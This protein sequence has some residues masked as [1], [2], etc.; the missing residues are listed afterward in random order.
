MDSCGSAHPARLSLQHCYA[1]GLTAMWV[2]AADHLIW[3][4]KVMSLFG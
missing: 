1:L 2:A 4:E 3:K